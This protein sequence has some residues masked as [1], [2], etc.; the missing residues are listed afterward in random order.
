MLGRL[1]RQTRELVSEKIEAEI[2][3]A[4]SQC[5]IIR[6][7]SRVVRSLFVLPRER[8]FAAATA[9]FDALEKFARVVTCERKSVLTAR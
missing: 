3:V 9:S 5:V 7:C 6:I 2:C 4:Q 1:L 8:C